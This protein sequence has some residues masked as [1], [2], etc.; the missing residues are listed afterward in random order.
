MAAALSDVLAAYPV[1]AAAALSA[2]L[3]TGVCVFGWMMVNRE[4]VPAFEAAIQASETEVAAT[5][6]AAEGLTAAGQYEAAR[7]MLEESLETAPPG[8]ARA[9]AEYLLAENA[10]RSLS[11]TV[12]TWEAEGV[13]LLIDDALERYPD[14]ARAPEALLWKGEL[15]ERTELPHAA[16]VV[17]ERLLA[18]R[19]DAAQRPTAA[20]ALGRVALELDRP[21]QA[22]SVVQALLDTAPPADTAAEARLLLGRALAADG[23]PDE[24]RAVLERLAAAR[25]DDPVGAEAL[26][27]MARVDMANGRHENAIDLLE[28][29]LQTSTTTEGK[30]QVFLTLADAYRRAG[31]HDEAARVLEELLDF[32]PEGPHTPEA[33]MAL[34]EVL[35]DQGRRAEAARLAA[36]TARQYPDRPDVLIH[37]ADFLARVGDGRAAA[38]RLL[39]ADAAGAEDPDVLLDAARLLRESGELELAREALVRLLRMY[40]REP[41]TFDAQVALGRLEFDMGLTRT[42]I[43]RMKDLVLQTEDGPRRLPLLVALGD[44]YQELALPARAAEVYEQAAGLTAEPRILARAAVALAEA[45]RPEAALR[46]ANRVD[47]N[48]LDPADGYALGMAKGRALRNIDPLRAIA[49]M[50]DAYYAYP[51]E[52]R[53]EDE[54]LLLEGYLLSD[55][56]TKARALVSEL[57]NYVRRHPVESPR[58]QQAALDWADYQFQRGDYHGAAEAYETAATTEGGTDAERDWARFQRANVLIRLDDYDDGI[59]E[60]EAI[61]ASDSEWADEAAMRL[62]Y[63]RLDREL[64]GIAPAAR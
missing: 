4:A 49:A 51:G 2:G 11:D 8:A 53:P 34:S 41:Q 40:P 24:A 52:R 15:Y 42:A 47:A 43:G 62:R 14:H 57:T 33:M 38:D 18:E 59:P 30:E 64:R 61:A 46:V 9:D 37:E 35:D 58:L 3:V 48:A 22:V 50:E 28:R 25:P 39:A 32:F 29:S 20:L 44:M 16:R 63:A 23:R 19:P 26:A 31:A 36:R 6:E 7:V 56:A 45:G 21:Q 55:Q 10:Y 17:Y 1:R 5:V 60:L 12:G 54:A 13:H 27:A